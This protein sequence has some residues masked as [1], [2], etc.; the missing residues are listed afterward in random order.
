MKRFLMIMGMLCACCFTQAQEQQKKKWVAPVR[1]KLVKWKGPQQDAPEVID[2]YRPYTIADNWFVQLG[3]GGDM[4]LA[5]NTGGHAGF[6]NVGPAF[7]IALGRNFSRV[8]ATR[9]NIAYHQQYG[10]ASDDAIKSH[11]A[12]GKGK[13]GFKMGMAHLDELVNLTNIFCP[14]DEKRK[15]NVQM[16]AGVG[17][18]YSWDF[19]KDTKDWEN[20]GYPVDKSDQISLD[21]RAGLQFSYMVS[22]GIDVTM[23]GAY[24]MVNDGYNGVKTKKGFGFD[25][26]V[27]A[28]VGLTLYLPDHY[29]DYRYKKIRKAELN[30]LRELPQVADYLDNEKKKEY[31]QREANEKVAFGQQMLTRV[32]FYVDR[33]F[34]NDDQMENLRIVADFL[35]KHPEVDIVVKSYNGASKG[36]ESPDMKLAQRRAEAVRKALVRHH[37]VD[38]SRIDIEYDEKADAPYPMKGEWIDAVVFQMERNEDK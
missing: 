20:Y 18:N 2:L 13:Y 10:W 26:Y 35:K 19:K 25:S 30:S 28:S 12:I 24:H 3:V 6:G 38:E 16:F 21:L 8:W 29:G 11:Q 34:V 14:Y 17:V 22:E 36:T 33:A 5:E 9:F 23:Q 7:D 15:L 1:P 4:S 27:S 37:H 32:S 31:R